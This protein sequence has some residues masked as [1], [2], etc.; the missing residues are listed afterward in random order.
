MN[1]E[2]EPE[3]PADSETVT[4]RERESQ[5]EPGDSESLGEPRR[6]SESL[7][8]G[9]RWAISKIRRPA[10]V[11]SKSSPDGNR[12]ERLGPLGNMVPCDMAM[13]VSRLLW[14]VKTDSKETHWIFKIVFDHASEIK[15]RISGHAPKLAI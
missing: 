11:M 12:S 6:T 10:A 8:H 14:I 7:S 15:N 2:L 9:V 13:V 5:P 4:E 1:S 3:S